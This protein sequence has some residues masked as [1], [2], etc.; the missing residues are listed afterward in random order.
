MRDDV[1][2]TPLL[3]RQP[4]QDASQ[5]NALISMIP[6]ALLGL[7]M[8]VTSACLIGF[9]KYLMSQ[10]RFPFPVLLVFMHCTAASCM[11]AVIYLVKP[12]VFKSL[13]DPERMVSIDREF[14]FKRA[15]PI[16]LLFSISLVFGNTAYEYC[17]VAFLQMVKESNCV[18]T[19]LLGLFFGTEFWKVKEGVILIGVV[20]ATSLTVRGELHYSALGFALQVSCCLAECLKTV[21]QS[22]ILAGSLKLDPLSYI[23]TVMPL[24]SLMLGSCLIADA[25]I[26]DIPGVDLP[27]RAQLLLTARLLVPNIC[28]ALLLNVLAATFIGYTSALAFVMINLL[29]DTAVVLIGAFVLKEEVSQL[30]AAGFALQLLC[31][32]WWGYEKQMATSVNAA[33]K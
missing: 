9:N 8:L 25:T 29:K 6:V 17:S 21:L 28:L 14:I 18:T 22:I 12:S 31:V 20:M 13:V 7:S 1:E 15:I 30:Q 4:R 33:K 26:V 3:Q 5:A 2:S 10:E 11:A 16:A 27:T 19:Y 24:C 32:G 23:L